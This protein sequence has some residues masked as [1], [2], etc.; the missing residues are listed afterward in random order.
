MSRSNKQ[1]QK[2]PK[3]V[4][5]QKEVEILPSEAT[6]PLINAQ[7][8]QIL[9][10]KEDSEHVEK[11]L[12]AE[13]DYNKQ[14]LAILREHA[15]HHPDAKEERSTKTF[16]RT[17]YSFLLVV[18]LLLLVAMPFVSLAVASVFGILC[19]L[20]VSGVLL[21]ARERDVDLASFVKIINMIVGRKQ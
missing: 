12:K 13:L 9:V 8:I 15:E 16:R 14:R 10:E 18:L 7:I 19:I 1:L 4:T 2:S 11:L 3:P 21:N 17:Q 5:P 6:P 20:I